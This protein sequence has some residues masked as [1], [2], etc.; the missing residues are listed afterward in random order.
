MLS[1]QQIRKLVNSRDYA[2]LIN[3]LADNGTTLP[4]PLQARLS[5][6]VPALGLALRRACELSYGPTPMIREMVH[7]LLVSQ[8]P[9][10]SFPGSTDR[11]PLATA[12]AAAGLAAVVRE[13]PVPDPELAVALDQAL[14]ALAS[15]QDG[16]ALFMHSDDRAI[17]DRAL[18]SAMI[19]FLLARVPRFRETCRFADL[20]DW[21]DER[22]DRL[23]EATA[24]LYHMASLDDPAR[25]SAC[26]A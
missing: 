22:A 25:V 16:Q 23:E 11:D 19:L 12:A 26:A 13:Q 21:F 14:A 6:P 5:H 17:E 4:L 10:G 8:N 2:R 15:M 18:T 9:D 24:E 20:M 3:C 1:T 7:E